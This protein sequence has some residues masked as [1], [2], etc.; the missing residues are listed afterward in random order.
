MIDV[1]VGITIRPAA[2]CSDQ[3]IDDDV[4]DLELKMS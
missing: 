3:L 2:G 1:G 4:L